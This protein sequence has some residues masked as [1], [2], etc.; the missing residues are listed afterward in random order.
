MFG[1]LTFMAAGHMCC[2]VAGDELVARI[3]PA[4][5]A[6]AVAEPHVRLCD[7]TGRPMKS[8]VTAAPADLGNAEA[9]KSWVDAALAFVETLPRKG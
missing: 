2:G 1:D 8:M 9:L 5:A 3:G 7:V 4:R 6:E